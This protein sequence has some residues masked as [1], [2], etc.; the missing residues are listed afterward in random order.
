ML[1]YGAIILVGLMVLVPAGIKIGLYELG[2]WLMA[3]ALVP[4]IYVSY[5]DIFVAAD[6][7]PAGDGNP[8][9]R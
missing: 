8:F 3:P 5:K 4:S 9:L 7:T 1:F 2:L 6:P